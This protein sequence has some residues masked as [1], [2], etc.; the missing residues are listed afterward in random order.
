MTSSSSRDIKDRVVLVHSSDELYGSDRMVLQ[1]IDSMPSDLRDR[2][3]VVLP[4]STDGPGDL[5][6]SLHDASVAVQ[7]RQLPILR[8]HDLK[9]PRA[10]AVLLW[11]T[12]TLARWLRSSRVGLVYAATSATAPAVVSARMAGVRW[13]GVHVQE[14]WGRREGV[15]LGPMI[16]LASTLVTISRAVQAALPTYLRRRAMVVE[17]GI[18]APSEPMV[19]RPE[20]GPLRFLVASRWNAW[21]GHRTL[22]EAWDCDEPPGELVVAGSAPTTGE[23]VD[24]AR[25]VAGLKH[26]ESVQ[27][28]G[29]IDSI[30][31]VLD[32]VDALI[33]PSDKPEPFGLVAI[34]AFSRGRAVIGSDGG[35]LA[36]LVENGADGLLFEPS[37]AESLRTKLMGIDR[38]TSRRLGSQ[39]RLKF[40][41]RYSAR[42][43]NDRMAAV[44]KQVD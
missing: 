28:I 11:R 31:D 30:F 4:T 44:W 21:K 8:R 10:L 22:L 17:N 43:F 26:P 37:N 20:E 35:G 1:I 5:S 6:H 18:E 14:V 33:V 3:V 24:V 40:D 12:L 9:S 13:I 19:T 16:G 36:Q 41:E 38:V 2:L 15:L 29:Q 27:I 42:A 23:A 34:E 32:D 25:I 39:G 7:H